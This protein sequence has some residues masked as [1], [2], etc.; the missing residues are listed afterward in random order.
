LK[1]TAPTC[2]RPRDA[3]Q[4]LSPKLS[5]FLTTDGLRL[6][7]IQNL[8]RNQRSESEPLIILVFG[9]IRIE[10][11]KSVVEKSGF[12]VDLASAAPSRPAAQNPIDRKLKARRPSRG[13]HTQGLPCRPHWLSLPAMLATL[14]MTSSAPTGPASCSSSPPA[15]PI[16]A[17]TGSKAA[18][19][20]SGG[21][22]AGI[23]ARRGPAARVGR[24]GESPANARVR[25]PE[26][27][28]PH[29]KR[30]RSVR[31]RP[32][33]ALE[34][35]GQDRPGILRLVAGVLGGRTA[36]NVLRAA[37]DRRAPDAGHAVQGPPCSSPLAGRAPRR[38]SHDRSD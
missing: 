24:T 6:P 29:R 34:L 15:W 21:Q 33:A 35:V 37:S 23:L 2:R 1:A 38:S 31:H 27:D 32:V 10:S 16:T 4:P 14:V 7:R 11:V 19:A 18:C 17:A 25:G 28:H 30:R 36:S 26:C 9:F 5:E 3:D 22:F 12:E 8:T 13:F 20:I